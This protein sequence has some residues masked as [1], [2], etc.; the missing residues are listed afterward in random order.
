MSDETNENNNEQEKDA[1]ETTKTSEKTSKK[2]K[3]KL[4]L[5]IVLVVLALGLL[6]KFG[7]LTF[8]NVA[9]DGDV[10]LGDANQIVATVIGTTIT[11]ADL[12]EKMDQVRLS[13]PE[14]AVDPTED[15][16]FELQLLEDLIDLELLTAAAMDK[17]YTVSD[18]E[19]DAEI[20][21]IIEQFPS[22]E[23]F[24]KQLEFVGVSQDELRD[25]IRVEMHIRQLLE[26]ETG[27]GSVEVSDE[28]ISNLYEL[29]VGDAEG[30]PPLEEVSE[31]IRAQITN[32]K[33]AQIIEEY[34]LGL[35]DGA[36]IEITL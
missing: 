4:I 25:N 34:V 6:W 30:V 29:S 8:N 1:P 7:F 26:E 36:E 9:E 12:D 20:A 5:T 32:Q 16:T 10:A 35:R 33:S 23:E 19:I 28:E 24:Y 27:I 22:E 21:L 11:R 31:V 2:G 14:G 13:L 15:A 17:N 3:N 18:D